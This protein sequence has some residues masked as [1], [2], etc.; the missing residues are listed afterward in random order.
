MA[1]SFVY[2]GFVRI[3]QLVRLGEA[4]PVAGTVK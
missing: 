3:L 1:L 2:L 4:G